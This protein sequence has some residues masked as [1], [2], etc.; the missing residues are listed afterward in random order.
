MM[1]E[2]TWKKKGCG[3]RVL[4]GVAAVLLAVECAFIPSEANAIT[5]SGP[6]ESPGGTFFQQGAIVNFCFTHGHGG[7]LEFNTVALGNC[8]PGD[9]QLSVWADPQ[10]VIPSPAPTPSG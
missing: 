6:A 8:P 1:S 4:L 10:G 7:W 3:T 9:V 2:L 5:R